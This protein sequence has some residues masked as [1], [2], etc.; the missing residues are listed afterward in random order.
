MLTKEQQGVYRPVV[1]KAW[2]EHCRLAG[3]APNN[4]PAYDAWYRDHVHS[5]IGVWSTKDADPRRD[6]QTLLD[7]FKL[8]AGEPQPIIIQGWTESQSTWFEREARKAHNMELSRGSTETD[9]RAWVTT[10]LVECDI[11]D[12]T[13]PD[14]KASF[15]Q[16]MAYVGT[17]SGDEGV[18]SHFAEATEIR[19]RWQIRRFMSDLA[20]LEQIPVEWAYVQAIWQQADLLPDLDEAPAAI[21]VKVLEMLDSHIRRLCKRINL[22]PKCL[23]SRCQGQCRAM[24]CPLTVPWRRK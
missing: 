18:I 3:T 2:T 20:A 5:S 10:L 11:H 13:A 16:V 19:M 22:C 12:H 17:I 15:D 14:R 9:F 8:L 23:P 6:F 7:R 24:D 1:N 21:M 4:K